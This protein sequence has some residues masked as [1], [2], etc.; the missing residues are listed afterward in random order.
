MSNDPWFPPV[1]LFEGEDEDALKR[2]F[3]RLWAKYPHRHA[4][5]IGQ[6]IFKG[7]IEPLRGLQAGAVWSR[8]LSVLELRDA[9]LRDGDGDED[10]IET[11][12]EQVLAEVLTKARSTVDPKDA[13]TLYKLWLEGKGAIGKGV[14]INNNNDNRTQTVNVL[15]VPAQPKTDEERELLEMRF[16]AHQTKLVANVRTQPAN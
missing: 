9:F 13:A 15:K 3:A 11:E 16:K 7:A 14:T 1:P 8:E 10:L 5:E 12:V 4:N 2:E 6:E